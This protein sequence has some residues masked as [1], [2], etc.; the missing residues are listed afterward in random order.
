[1]FNISLYIKTVNHITDPICPRCQI[2]FG[3][4]VIK[5]PFTGTCTTC[6]QKYY[7]RRFKFLNIIFYC[8]RDQDNRYSMISSIK[9]SGVTFAVLGWLGLTLLYYFGYFAPLIKEFCESFV[10]ENGYA[11]NYNLAVITTTL[12]ASFLL[13]C[14]P[15]GISIQHFIFKGMHDEYSRIHDISPDERHAKGEGAFNDLKRDAEESL[16]RIEG[17]SANFKWLIILLSSVSII[18]FFVGLFSFHRN[19][20]EQGLAGFSIY[21]LGCQC[22]LVLCMFIQG[23]FFSSPLVEIN[24][25]FRRR[26]HF[27]ELAVND[28]KSRRQQ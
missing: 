10:S 8:L 20:C 28:G 13:F 16:G 12:S 4:Q 3:F 9:Y 18:S 17:F 23:N 27:L 24:K 11:A 25:A 2:E 15:L 6:H 1:M 7:I 19:F 21:L 5:F 22:W 14:A 26:M